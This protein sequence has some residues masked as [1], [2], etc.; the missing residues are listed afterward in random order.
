MGETANCSISGTAVTASEVWVSQ[1]Y[2]RA[3]HQ[4]VPILRYPEICT[5]QKDGP[6]S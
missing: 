6:T 3:D 5:M 2:F 1:Q 4:R